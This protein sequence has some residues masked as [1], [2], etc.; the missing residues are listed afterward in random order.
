MQ[1]LIT[2]FIIQSKECKLAE[3][4]KFTVI[5]KPAKTDIANKQITPSFKEIHFN[6]REE[7]ISDE[8]VKYVAD[9][10]EISSFEAFSEIKKWCVETKEK[11]RNGE[12]ILLNSLGVL[13][14]ESSG[15][16]FF[17]N[18]IGTPFFAPV[19]AERVIHKNSEHAVL[20]GDRQTTSSVMNQFYKEEETATK[21][22]AWK[23]I[24]IILLAI[25]L[26][27]LFFHFYGHPFSLSEFGNQLKTVPQSP[28]ATYLNK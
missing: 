28:P 9:K 26:V 8:L 7:K 22:N 14:K 16:I 4:G 1:D 6:K 11:L 20:V 19:A 17:E 24:A 27:I 3:I 10:K 23:I 18:R 15:N 12:E 13:K 25:A 21:S 2:S 5:T